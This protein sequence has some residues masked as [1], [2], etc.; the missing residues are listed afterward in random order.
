MKIKNRQTIYNFFILYNYKMNNI[1]MNNLEGLPAELKLN[2]LTKY[3]DLNSV[4]K[5]CNN[6]PA[7]FDICQMYKSEI[8]AHVFL[9]KYGKKSV[10]S[11][12]KVLERFDDLKM[13]K[14]LIKLGADIHANND[15][16][17]RYSVDR[18]YLN[19]VKFLVENG[20]NIHANDDEALIHS[21]EN[22]N[23]EMVNYLVEKGANIHAQDDAAMERTTDR[24]VFFSLMNYAYPGVEMSKYNEK[25]W[26]M[27]YIS[28]HYT[29]ED[30]LM[31][32][33]PP[34]LE[35]KCKRPKEPVTLYRG[36][37]PNLSWTS[38]EV[39]YIDVKNNTIILKTNKLSSWTS[40]E[41]VALKFGWLILCKQFQPSEIL[42]DLSQDLSIEQ[43][44][45]LVYPGTYK[46]YVKYNM[47]D[48]LYKEGSID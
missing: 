9:N 25:P 18:G 40:D 24:Y 31:Y 10:F 33:V 43:K 35:Q 44:E 8:V 13:V 4:K 41:E 47:L 39:N 16:A 12:E 37:R 20:A 28:G 2:I 1:A 38:N 30:R 36:I 42:C 21:A 17:L 34:Y 6:I 29:P 23:L 11:K 15:I 48:E 14:E 19:V 27:R 7:Y 3:K 32:N 45:F 22:G 46:C 26:L 5:M